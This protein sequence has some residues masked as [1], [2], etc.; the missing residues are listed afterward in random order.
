MLGKNNS[1]VVTD[2][3]FNLLLT[4][5]CLFFLAFILVNDPQESEDASVDSDALLLITMSWEQ[6]C[7]IDIW[8]KTPIGGSDSKLY[9]AR[10]EVGPLHLD[11][12]V[13]G[14][15]SYMPPSR[16]EVV[17]KHNQEIVSVRGVLEGE[18]I[19]NAHY[20]GGIDIAGDV[21][22]SIMIQDVKSKQVIYM[23]EKILSGVGHEAHF[24]TIDIKEGFGGRPNTTILHDKPGRM[25]VGM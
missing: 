6:D 4:F 17:I 16:E 8:I 23:E 22:V 15:R 10:R 20:F 1:S 14:W 21:P 11:L 3:L 18:Y 19:I 5:V 12:D 24:V 2:L 9:Y 25:I 7:D 13:V